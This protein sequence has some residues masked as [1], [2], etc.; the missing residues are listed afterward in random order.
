MVW[1]VGKKRNRD[2]KLP[3]MGALGMLLACSAASAQ[4]PQADLRGIHLYT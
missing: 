1:C 3:S 4:S 2:A